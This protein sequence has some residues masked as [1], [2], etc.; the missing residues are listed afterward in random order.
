MSLFSAMTLSL[1]D[2]TVNAAT[3]LEIQV[4]LLSPVTIGGLFSLSIGLAD[5]LI[6]TAAGCEVAT[7]SVLSDAFIDY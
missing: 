2:S 6:N 1:S 7:N 4:T 3:Y 5:L